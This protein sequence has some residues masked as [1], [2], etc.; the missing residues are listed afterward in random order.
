MSIIKSGKLW[1]FAIALA[2]TGVVGLGAWTIIETSKAD[3]QPSDAY[4]TN[5]QDADANANKL[6]KS[7]IAFDKE[8]RLKYVTEQIKENGCDVKYAL[9]TKDGKAVEGAKMV[10]EISRPEVE[11]Y[12]KKFDNPK[13]EE[14]LYVFHDVK[15]PKT[16][17]WNLM[18]KVDAGDKSR[19]YA[20]KT[21]TRIKN[22]RSI[23]EAS[24]Y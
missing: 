8:Y 9:T 6:I 7:R 11:T 5:Y 2:I 14:N 20:I 22:D 15:F 24:Q 23:Q 19:F 12:T 16:G 17:V 10:L 18:L 1:P 13:F 21:D 3:I 4:M